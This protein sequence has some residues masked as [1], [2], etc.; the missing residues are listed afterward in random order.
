[1]NIGRQQPTACVC[2]HFNGSMDELRLWNVVRTQ[3]Q[4]LTNMNSTI[5]TSSAGLVAY[6][7]FDEGIGTTTADATSN[8]NNGTLVNSPTWQ[9]PATSPVNAVLWSPSGATTPSIVA[10]TTNTY[11][12]TVTNGYGCISVG[13][14]VV[15]A[16]ASPMPT[17]QGIGYI[18]TG[19][20]ISL[21]ATGCS[22]SVGTYTL[23]WYKSS[24]NTSVT[25]PVSPTTTTNYYAKCEQVLNGIT[26]FSLASANVTVNVGN[27]INSIITGNW[28]NSNTWTPS[29]IPLP[30]DIVI[31]NNH[32]VTITSNAAN[33]KRVEYK[34]GAT[35]N[36]LNAAAKLKVGF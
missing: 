15:N 16:L 22:G 21:T 19:G 32:T 33:A 6:F 2:N 23:K 4:M 28:E 10:T 34:T 26:C 13:S 5:P 12:A 29:R 27:Y 3:T 17:P 14:I 9:V 11:M 20:S 25:M 24:D 30:T 7:K 1:M 31:I 35:L 36:Y 18:P 8:G